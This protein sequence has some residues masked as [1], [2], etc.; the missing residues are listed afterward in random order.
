M[1]EPALVAVPD[2]GT[3]LVG[4]AHTDTV[5]ELLRTVQPLLDRLVVL[6]VPPQLTSVDDIV[7]W[8]EAFKDQ[9]NAA[10]VYFPALR[11]PTA[12]V[13]ASGHIAGVIARLDAERGAHHTPANAVVL[14]AVDL[15][16]EL[17]EP[18]QAR[19]FEANVNLVRC[20]RG[21]GLVVWGGRTLNGF[22]AHR[23]LIHLITR[24]IR[25]VATPLVF[26][27]NTPELRLTLVRAVTSV[28]LE[29]FRAGALKGTRPEEAFRITVDDDPE[30]IVCHVE[31][32]P[33][34]PM[35][36]ILLKLVLGQDRALE[37]I[38]A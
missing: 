3:D 37:V 12:T 21:R 11:T 4:A 25:R 29:A 20:T 28:L 18:Q 33:A 23:R 17:P 15:A 1:P 5:L 22:V 14:E 27:T 19:L 7:A 8:T 16:T 30:Q 38:E 36:F 32:A 6:D 24:A 31:V 13:P 34:V 10:A 35:E 2:L 9:G 26:D